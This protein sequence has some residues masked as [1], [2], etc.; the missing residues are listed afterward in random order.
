MGQP[1]KELV[2]DMGPMINFDAAGNPLLP[3]VSSLL[4]AAGFPGGAGVGGTNPDGSAQD[5]AMS[6][7]Q[8]QGAEQCSLM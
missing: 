8:A 6:D 3:D 2:G 4:G 5:P 7:Q 1:P